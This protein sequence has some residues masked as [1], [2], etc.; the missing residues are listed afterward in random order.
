ML[1]EIGVT[2]SIIFPFSMTIGVTPMVIPSRTSRRVYVTWTLLVAVPC[3]VSILFSQYGTN[4]PD[5]IIADC[6]FKTFIRGFAIVSIF[7]FSSIA[8]ISALKFSEL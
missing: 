6:P 2:L 7:P 5:D 8:F 1:D 3:V 4:F